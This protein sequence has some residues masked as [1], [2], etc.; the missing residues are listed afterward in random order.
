M[1]KDKAIEL[2]DCLLGMVDDNQGN[3]YDEAFHMAIDALKE[4]PEPLIVNFAREM[5]RE[6]IEKLKKEM[7]NAP[8]LI[9][10]VNDS[11]QPESHWIPCSERLPEEYGEY[12]IT[13]ITSASEK[14]F[15]GDAEFEVSSVWD[16]EHDRFM[17]DWLLDDYI[18]NYPDVKVLAW[19][20]LDE[21]WRGE[22]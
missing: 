16:D 4:Q 10:A 6:T 8:V 9:M 17:G 18:K 20:P 11:A 21:P 5:D 22:E 3:D 19:K 2:L 13:W 1:T 14:R 12:W 15:I 7:E